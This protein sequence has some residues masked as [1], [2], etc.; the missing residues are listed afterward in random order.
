MNDIDECSADCFSDVSAD[1]YRQICER[2]SFMSVNMWCSIVMTLSALK[3]SKYM[4]NT[5]HHML[6]FDLHLI[7]RKPAY[8]AKK[9]LRRSY[10]RC[11]RSYLIDYSLCS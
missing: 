6:Y 11:L 3:S 5:L 10:S 4:E 9:S 7:K 1:L 8:L 2:D